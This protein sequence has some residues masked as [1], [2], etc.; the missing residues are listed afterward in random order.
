MRFHHLKIANQSYF[1]HF[2]DSFYYS[3][4]AFQA[5]LCFLLH[6]IYPDVCTTSGSSIIR[7]LNDDIENKY[8][9]LKDGN[10]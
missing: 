7:S 8:K 2:K 3:M 9:N 5:S 4:I 1:T 10:E 6:A